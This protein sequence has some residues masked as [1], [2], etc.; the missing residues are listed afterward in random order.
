MGYRHYMYGIDKTVVE[1][2]KD[3]SREELIKRFMPNE[4]QDYFYHANL[5]TEEIYELGKYIEFV[6]QIQATG[7]PLFNR[8]D[9]KE[10]LED[11][12][13]YVIGREGLIKLIEIYRG[14]VVDYYKSLLVDDDEKDVM[15][16][17]PRKAQ[18]KQEHHIQTIINEWE[19]G[20][21][22]NTDENTDVITTS[23]K[24]EYSLFELVRIL[25]TFNFEQKTILFYGW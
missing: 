4:E 3:M 18:Q 25:K 24:Y 15:V 17:N 14:F 13:M 20:F 22:I 7:K 8:K 6:D 10:E 21:A 9:T 2:I 11:Y 12:D 23:W 16:F 19:R 5:P 1:E